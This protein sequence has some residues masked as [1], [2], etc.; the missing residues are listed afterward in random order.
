MAKKCKK[1]EYI[2]PRKPRFICEKCERMAKKKEKL[3]KPK[4]LK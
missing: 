4:K 2:D 1:H 3:C